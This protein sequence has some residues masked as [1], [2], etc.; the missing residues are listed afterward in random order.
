MQMVRQ[1]FLHTNI[2][3]DIVFMK[4][5]SP[6]SLPVYAAGLAGKAERLLKR[7]NNTDSFLFGSTIKA[8]ANSGR[9]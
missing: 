4:K 8:I 6:I 2:L 5:S 7:L 9:S 3:C 1:S